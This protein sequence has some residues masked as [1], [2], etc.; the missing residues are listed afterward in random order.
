M[1]SVRYEAP[2][3]VEAAVRLLAGESGAKVLSGGTDLIVQMRLMNRVP[4]L[5]LD[6]LRNAGVVLLLLERLAGVMRRLRA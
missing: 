6:L 2:N 5:S 1:E 4:R 3:N